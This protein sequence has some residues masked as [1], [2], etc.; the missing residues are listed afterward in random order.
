MSPL[1]LTNYAFC[2][3]SLLILRQHCPDQAGVFH[4]P[5][6]PWTPALSL[7]VSLILLT[8]SLAESGWLALGSVGL[9]VLPWPCFRLTRRARMAPAGTGYKI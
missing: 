5:L 9:M 6:F 8:G 1:L 2:F 7:L 3:L 4:T